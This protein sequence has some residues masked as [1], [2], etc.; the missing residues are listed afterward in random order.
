MTN[1]YFGLNINRSLSE[2]AD[3]TASLENINLSIRDLNKIRGLSSAGVTK[4]DIKSVS[5]MEF[6]A[7]KTTAALNS[8]ISLY[9]GL[10][11]NVFDQ[12]SFLNTNLNISGSLGAASYKYRYVD[13]NDNTIK[14]AEVSTSRVSSWST[15]ETPITNATPIF[16]GGNVRVEGPIELSKLI[17]SNDNITQRKYESE[18]PTNTVQATINGQNV[19]LY[20]MKGIPISFSGFFRNADV[21]ASIN[22]LNNL[23][24]SWVVRQINS[25]AT[26]FEFINRLSGSTSQIN[27]RSSFA[28]NRSIEFYYPPDRIT[29]LTITG[30]NLLD[31]PRIILNGLATLNISSNDL[32]EIPNFSGFTALTS[33]NISL[34]NL[35]RSSNSSLRTFNSN[36]L[37]R[38]PSSL[39]NLTMGSTYGGN[40]TAD[41]TTLSNLITLNLSSVS[42]VRRFTGT[43]PAINGNTIQNYNMDSNSFSAIASS[44]L[45]STSLKNISFSDNRKLNQINISFPNAT[46]LENI[47]ISGTTGTINLIDAVNKSKLKGYN[48]NYCNFDSVGNNIKNI[49]NGCT[50]LENINVR[51]SNVSGGFPA[52]IGCTKITNI[53]LLN[54]NVGNFSV[55]Y[56]L[57]NTTFDFC[58]STLQTL[59]WESSAIVTTPNPQPIQINTFKGLFNL[60][61]LYI[62]SRKAG[63]NGEI[64]DTLF[65]DCRSLQYVWLPNN[66]LSGNFPI[67]NNSRN[68][69]YVF[70]PNNAF[71]GAVP[72]INKSNFRYLY[73][74]NN[75]LTDFNPIESSAL[76]VLNL[77]NNL[78]TGV[79]N[80]SN[81]ISLQELQLNNN[82]ISTYSKGAFT[83][84]RSLRILN[85]N[86]N[87][88][89][90]GQIDD[91][92]LDLN[93]N[94]NLSPR[95]N[96][97]VNLRGP[98]NAAPSNTKEIRDIIL[99]LASFGWSIAVN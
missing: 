66:N 42:G 98:N 76:L 9:G 34:N 1:F 39:T 4:S 52:L 14:T 10:T 60:T 90:Q 71:T 47:S 74:Q 53:N 15:F 28:A 2:I 16:Y 73:L 83:T 78:I 45:N 7:E 41:L 22:I 27:F 46:N 17:L 8:E 23:R 37:A 25:T 94:Y 55:D 3:K 85:L 13:F 12:N 64:P 63:M 26:P 49:F 81:L 44:V 95:R 31:F 35:T 87:F 50:E 96:V 21:T 93:T 24:P 30:V 38:L 67:F 61:H 68:I 65:A 92:I 56:V 91:I 18:I 29:S 77:S 40:I 88:L 51:N 62:S 82:L 20:A 43:S 86:N 54:T 58:R 32:R 72:N 80:I 75:L 6:D 79:P 97:S 33:L 57:D 84:L 70:A 36:V 99:R 69:F 11:E 59:Y 48:V 5:N 19:Y 89:T